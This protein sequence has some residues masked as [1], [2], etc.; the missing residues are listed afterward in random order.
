MSLTV[1]RW[2]D[3]IAFL[4][5]GTFLVIGAYLQYTLGII[6]CPLCIIQRFLITCLGILFLMGALFN[7]S[8]ATRSFLHTFTFL[9]SAIGAAVASRQ[10]WLEHLP[11]DKLVSC[12]ASL[13]EYSQSAFFQQAIDF[14]FKGTSNCGT[15][16]WSFLGLSIPMWSLLLFLFLI[17]LTLRQVYLNRIT[18][19]R[20]A[21]F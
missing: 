3:F 12:K 2:T 18:H 6:P 15:N 19:K 14:F 17:I 1:T 13:A 21:L 16:S 7:F 9:L 8:P 5:C 10:L 20:N 11:S 4:I